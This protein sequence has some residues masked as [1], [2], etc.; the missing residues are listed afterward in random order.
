MRI[1]PLYIETSSPTKFLWKCSDGVVTFNYTGLSAIGNLIRTN[2]TLSAQVSGVTFNCNNLVANPLH[3]E[4]SSAF[5]GS[6][7]VINYE[8]NDV[9]QV[10]PISTSA[11]G[12]LVS[13]SYKAVT[14]L[15]VLVDGVH[16]ETIGRSSVG[17]A[18]INFGGVAKVD[19][20]N[21]RN[22]TTGSGVDADGLSV[23]GTDVAT[24]TTRL[25]ARVEVT[26]STFQDC[27]GRFI[28]LQ[29]SD[30]EVHGCTFILTSGVTTINEF[31]GL[32]AQAGGGHFHDC[33]YIFGSGIT[34][35][36]NS[37]LATIQAIRNDG[38]DDTAHIH[39]INVSTKAAG[40]DRLFTY[41]VRYGENTLNIHDITVNG[42]TV[43]KGLL[44][45][46][47]GL[48]SETDKINIQ[49][50]SVSVTDY[51]GQDFFKSSNNVDFGDKLYL[52]FIN[53]NVRNKASIAR[54]Y[55][56]N[57]SFSVGSN[58]LI[59]NNGHIN[60]RI[61]WVFDLDE[62]SDGNA[63]YT[64]GQAIAGAPEGTFAHYFTQ[65]AIQHVISSTGTTASR[66]TTN[67]DGSSWNAW[68]SV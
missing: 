60:D 57:A 4:K 13:G 42:E 23:F 35:G 59:A 63:F 9:R 10:D 7:A 18:I 51:S 19:Q 53:N 12:L 21:V 37:T 48:L 38:V 27:L 30:W 5:G 44:F 16:H 25:G 20:L 66:R 49:V 40:L 8:A 32:D 64:G 22:V 6:V 45:G 26:N 2:N 11:A 17:A 55:D 41:L 33:R 14:Y 56:Q 43:K 46:I 47:S 68:V 1:H 28:K 24:P 65:A 34:W 15:D 3:L 50:K 54:L 39:D 36:N 67:N 52:E 61:D 29:V 62:L 58:F 31:R